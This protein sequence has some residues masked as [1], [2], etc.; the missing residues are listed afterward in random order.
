MK[1]KIFCLNLFLIL[2]YT[3]GIINALN[4]PLL[5]KVIYIESFAKI[6]SPTITGRIVYKFADD[7]YIQGEEM[8]KVYPKAHYDGEIY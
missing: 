7:F 3:I 6:N 1:I 5:G 4:L 2:L 8:K